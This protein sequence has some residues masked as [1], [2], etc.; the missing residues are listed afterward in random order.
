MLNNKLVYKIIIC[1][2]LLFLLCKNVFAQ[3]NLV[4]NS[5][6]E[7]TAYNKVYTYCGTSGGEEWKFNDYIEKWWVADSRDAVDITI[8]FRNIPTT[9]W[10][11]RTICTAA[12]NAPLNNASNRFIGMIRSGTT[13]WCEGVRVELSEKLKSG[14]KY[15]I[16]LKMAQSGGQLSWKHQI[17]VHLTENEQFNISGKNQLDVTNFTIPANSPW[18]WTSFES[19]FTIKEE[20]DNI[21]GN[22]IIQVHYSDQDNAYTYIDDV[23][24]YEYCPSQMLIENRNHTFYEAPFEAARINAGYEVGTP[25]NGSGTVVVKSGA[26]VGYK[27]NDEVILSPGFSVENGA[28]FRA[29]NAP[30]GSD[31]FPPTSYAGADKSVCDNIPYPIGMSPQYGFNYSWSAS[32]ASAISYLSNPNIANPTFTRPSSG[33]GNVIYTLTVSNNCG[34][35][36]SDNLIIGYSAG[37]GSNF[38]ITNLSC[39]GT[40]NRLVADITVEQYTRGIVISLLSYDGKT[41]IKQYPELL[42]GIDFNPPN[43]HWVLPDYVDP[44]Q[45]YTLWVTTDIY[46]HPIKKAMY[47]KWIPN[48]TVK[49][50]AIP[51]V[52]TPNGDGINDQFCIFQEGATSYSIEIFNRSGGTRLYVNSGPVTSKTVCLWSGANNTNATYYY[53]LKLRNSCTPEVTYTGNVFRNGTQQRL[54]QHLNEE[55]NKE[56]TIETT[57]PEESIEA[58]PN[59]NEGSF[60]LVI[61]EKYIDNSNV[62]VYNILGK[63]VYQSE[64]EIAQNSNID[65]SGY[66]KGIYYVKVISGNTTFVK[67]V[68]YQ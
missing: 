13:Y 20:N 6:F 49:A 21:L 46:C 54:S 30:C 59:P 10:L 50:T 37:G 11:D 16:R 12:S 65:I 31:C 2:C 5:G 40:S 41:T 22:L 44:C 43:V 45:G 29:W 57:G 53:I 28:T 51:D 7:N 26:N 8:L 39:A 42:A 25:P 63:L 3:G 61:P 55:E 48:P 67:K 15:A 24:L 18:S 19:N 34:Q 52:F 47:Y 64:S 17:R 27:A 23:E 68:I 38:G 62:Y 14:K 4:P 58:Y 32:P 36:A 56:T 35:A 33:Y 1:H 60:K 9:D 66:S